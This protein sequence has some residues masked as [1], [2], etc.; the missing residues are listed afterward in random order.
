MDT[1]DSLPNTR[2]LEFVAW[3]DGLVLILGVPNG[4]A[5]HSTLE[6]LRCR[7]GAV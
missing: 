4:K 6:A 2:H 5:P 3:Y 1:R 7:D